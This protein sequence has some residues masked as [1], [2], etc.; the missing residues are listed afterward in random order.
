MTSICKLESQL[1]AVAN[2]RRL[3]MLSFIKREKSATAGEIATAVHIS[4]PPASQHFRILRAAG[5][6]EQKK[7]G[8]FMTY[9]LSLKQEEPIKQILSML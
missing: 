2:G 9:R 6:I 3:A 7:R 8:K 1:K 4:M 5:I